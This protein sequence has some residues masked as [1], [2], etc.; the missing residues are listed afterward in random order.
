MLFIDLRKAYDSIPRQALWCVLEKYGIPPTMLSV[1][2]SLHEGMRAGVTVD[3]QVASEFEVCNG[4]IQGCVI[5]PTFFNLYFNVVVNQ[6]REKCSDFGVDILYKCGGKLVGERTR[7]PCHLRISELLFADDAVAVGTSRSGI[8]HAAGVLDDLI[9]KWGLTLSI[10]KTKLLVAGTPCSEEGEMRPLKLGGGEVECVTDFKYLGSVLDGKGDMMKEVEERIAKA[11]RA[12]VALREPVFKNS[13]QSLKTKRMVYRAVVLG[14][15]L[16][17]SETWT[18]KRATTRKL[19]AFHNR[20]LRGVLGISA[21][22]QRME[23]ISSVQVAKRFGME[24]SLEDMIIA[25]RLRWL[26]HV[27]RMSDERIPKK[28]MFGWL[29]QRRPAHGTKMRWRD[30]VRRDLRKFCIEESS[31]F[32]ETQERDVWRQK[33]REGLEESTKKRLYEDEMRRR[34]RSA[35]GSKQQAS[36][37][38]TMSFTCST[39]LR[40]FRR[41]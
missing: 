8:E 23:R 40:S 10:S 21:A 11:S 29:P 17:G 12:F 31:W 6:W 39:C 2:C 20:C 4:L 15:L 14:V 28:I 38:T 5:A 22:Q 18:T 3:G 33:C 24:E 19:E 36:T 7:R 9:S 30:R 35:A 16:Y 26:G 1:M 25:R 37:D 27:A 13:N 34:V 41:R 32:R